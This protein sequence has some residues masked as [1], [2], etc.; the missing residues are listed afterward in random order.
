MPSIKKRARPAAP[1]RLDETSNTGGSFRSHLYHAEE[2][3]F[4]LIL[5]PDAEPKP[6]DWVVVAEVGDDVMISLYEG[7]Q[8]ISVVRVLEFYQLTQSEQ[9]TPRAEYDCAN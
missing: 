6:C 9:W 8:Y 1:T 3:D 5:D 4:Y 7:Q 2:S